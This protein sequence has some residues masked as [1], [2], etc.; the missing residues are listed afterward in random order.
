MSEPARHLD[1]DQCASLALGLAS[2]AEHASAV[3]HARTC[4]ACETRLRAHVGA[5][6]RARADLARGAGMQVVTAPRRT[7]F[8][9]I[10]IIAATAAAA[11]VIAVFVV[12][13][14]SPRTSAAPSWL[15]AP[16]AMVQTRSEEPVDDALR[17]G[18]EAY[19][20]HDLP[21]AISALRS[22][23]ATG[24]AE[25]A[26]RL[27]LGHALLVSGQP[28]EARTWLESV[29]VDALPDP[30]RGEAERSLAAVWRL[31]GAGRQAD[32]IESAAGR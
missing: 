7:A 17:A 18:L 25:Q 8:R 28:R 13:A 26:R 10:A 20:R 24:G 1:D 4:V 23:H 32:S 14:P 6:V 15:T 27:Y 30:W 3:A 21:A 16:G 11:A 2:A 22:A 31:T 9:R 5:G 12:R 29:D 19:A